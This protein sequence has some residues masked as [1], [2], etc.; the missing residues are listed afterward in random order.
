MWKYRGHYA[1]FCMVV[2]EMFYGAL[3]LLYYNWN[4]VFLMVKSG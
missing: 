1:F 2:S 4:L 3:Y